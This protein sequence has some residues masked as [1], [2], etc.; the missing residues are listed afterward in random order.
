MYVG[1]VLINDDAI[2]GEDCSIY[3]NV[4]LI[5]GGLMIVLLNWVKALSWV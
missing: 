5:A 4:G 3:M 2:I 1:P